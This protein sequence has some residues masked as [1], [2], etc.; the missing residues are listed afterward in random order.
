ML[1]HAKWSDPVATLATDAQ[2][3]SLFSIQM[4]SPLEFHSFWAVYKVSKETIK[5]NSDANT[6]VYLAINKRKYLVL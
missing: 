5:N 4:E 6:A 1:L 2:L 3:L